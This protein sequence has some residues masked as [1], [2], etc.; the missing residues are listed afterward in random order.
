MQ[1]SRSRTPDPPTKRRKFIEGGGFLTAG[2]LSKSEL[3]PMELFDSI[4]A[5]ALPTFRFISSY[6]IPSFVITLDSGADVRALLTAWG[7]GPQEVGMREM[8]WDGSKEFVSH[9]PEDSRPST[10]HRCGHAARGH[11]SAGHY[12]SGGGRT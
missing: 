2:P 12:K 6:S 10:S 5:D 9:A 3:S 7:T 1:R 11:Y 4:I 8:D